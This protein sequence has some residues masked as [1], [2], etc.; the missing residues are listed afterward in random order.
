MYNLPQQ[1][2]AGWG[3]AAPTPPIQERGVGIECKRL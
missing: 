1:E 2:G 3:G